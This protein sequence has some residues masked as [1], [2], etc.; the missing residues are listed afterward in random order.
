MLKPKDWGYS[1][2]DALIRALG[3]V[4]EVRKN[5]FSPIFILKGL[6]HGKLHIFLSRLIVTKTFIWVSH[7]CTETALI[8]IQSP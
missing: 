6:C 3:D 5:L 7:F 2:M 8:K 4:I 1:N